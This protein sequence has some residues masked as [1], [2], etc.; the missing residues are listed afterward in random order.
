MKNKAK[1]IK[2]FDNG[3]GN[4]NNWDSVSGLL[5]QPIEISVKIIGQ[6]VCRLYFKKGNLN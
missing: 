6:I 4:M 3:K 2:A 1:G 5:K